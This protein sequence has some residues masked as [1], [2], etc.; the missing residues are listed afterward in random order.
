MQQRYDL[1]LL[2]V[3]VVDDCVNDGAH[4]LGE[5]GRVGG[6]L[7]GRRSSPPLFSLVPILTSAAFVQVSPALALLQTN[8]LFH[9]LQVAIFNGLQHH[10]REA[11]QAKKLI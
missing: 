3:S 11:L 5:F 7:F 6:E 10:T 2:P 4:L 8:L 9:L 1:V